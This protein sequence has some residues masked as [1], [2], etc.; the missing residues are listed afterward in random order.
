MPDPFAAAAWFTLLDTIEAGIR[1]YG[2]W[3][4][5]ARD[6]RDAVGLRRLTPRAC[7][8]IVAALGN[9]G[10]EC[11]P[12]DFRYESVPLMIG[13]TGAAE[14]ARTIEALLPA[15]READRAVPP[16]ATW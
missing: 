1:R 6:L 13:R 16:G 3:S 10:Y 2:Y 15:I 7:A 12:P 14:I 5:E 11:E 4:G 9:S 8:R